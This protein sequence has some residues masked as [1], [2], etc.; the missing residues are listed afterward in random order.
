MMKKIYELIDTDLDI[1]IFGVADD[2]RDVEKGYLFVATK[3]FNVDHFDYI[4]DAISKGCACIITDRA[5]NTDIPNIIV[6]DINSIYYDICSK[7]YDV[8]LD[9]FSFIGVTGTD[10]KTTTTYIVKQLIDKVRKSTYIGTNGA[11]IGSNKLDV[12]NTT[13][14]ISELYNVLKLAREANSKDIVMEV[15][16]EA[17]LHDRLKNFKFDIAGFT[18]I[19]EDHLNVHKTIDNYIKCK[20]KLLDLVRTSGIVIVNGDDEICKKI[21][22]NNIVK[23][24]FNKEND[25]IIKF[26]SENKNNTIFTINYLGNTY[27]II[28]PF[29][30]IYNIYNV[31][32]AFLICFHYGLSPEYLVD[33]IYNLGVVS[34]RREILDFGQ[35]FEII[36][37]YAHTLNGIKNVVE[38]VD[39]GK[40]I[41]VVTGCA[42]GREKSKRKLI[43]EYLLNNVDTCIFTM[44]DPRFENVNDIID[45]MVSD[46]NIKYLRIIDRKDAIYKAFDIADKDSVVLILGKGRDNYMA[47]EDKKIPYCDYD[48]I[49]GYFN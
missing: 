49:S 27:K 17:L 46:N 26:L 13:P 41:I 5:I 48:I 30:G 2:S 39:K 32:M 28:S 38:S 7:F 21:E 37:D 15:S 44:D 33:A 47:I 40:N 9:N 14:C 18:N 35:E 20:L 19:T 23:F 36:L 43:G 6:S 3:G 34:G 29:K 42:G 24:G 12:H 25:C 11:E 16:S 45:D 8:C 4:D 10:G 1:D 22:F 31:T